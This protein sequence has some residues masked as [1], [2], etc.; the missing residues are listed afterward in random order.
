MQALI[1]DK[2]LQPWEKSQGF[3]KTDVPEPTLHRTKKSDKKSIIIKVAYAGVCGTD[4]GLWYR[5]NF[6]D[7][8]LTSLT[9]EKKNYRVIG[10]EVCGTVVAVGSDV[11][12]KYEI[13]VGDFITTESHLICSSCWQCRHDQTNVCVNEKIIGISHDGGF[14]EYIKLP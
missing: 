1:Y 10:H 14:A 2:N 5:Q 6:K 8:V 11:E 3:I 4:R 13:T 7:A 12:E 9:S